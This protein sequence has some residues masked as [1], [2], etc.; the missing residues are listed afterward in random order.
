VAQATRI[1]DGLDFVVPA[2]SELVELIDTAADPQ[3]LIRIASALPEFGRDEAARV[4][5][6]KATDDCPAFGASPD[7]DALR[8]PG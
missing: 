4:A 8:D 2:G 1:D 6:A 5:Y 7:L 3:A